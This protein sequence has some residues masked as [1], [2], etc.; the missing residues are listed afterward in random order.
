MI[1]DALTVVETIQKIK[2]LCITGT[3]VIIELHNDTDGKLELLHSYIDNWNF[4]SNTIAGKGYFR[5]APDSF[6]EPKQISVFSAEI[7]ATGIGMPSL[8][9]P[10][11]NQSHFAGGVIYRYSG[12]EKFDI[13]IE[14]D[15][16]NILKVFTNTIK[17]SIGDINSLN[18]IHGIFNDSV[19]LAVASD[20]IGCNTTFRY[21]GKNHILS[22]SIGT[23][24]LEV[25]L[26]KN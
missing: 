12:E 26:S 6:I 15:K 25:T 9:A 11:V 7:T 20:A 1:A 5:N 14:F 13:R 19:E 8:F 2:D 17:G 10:F 18:H 3:E 16:A 24:A 23:E 21:E 4:A 22:A